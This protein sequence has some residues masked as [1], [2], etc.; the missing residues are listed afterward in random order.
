MAK[1]KKTLTELLAGKTD[2]AEV[3]AIAVRYEKRRQVEAQ[4]EARRRKL[5]MPIQ[6]RNKLTYEAMTAEVWTY[7]IAHYREFRQWYVETQDGA[8][9]STDNG[10]Q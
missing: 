10:N 9:L 4:A 5:F 1:N 7:A 8:T 2:P 6:T 3:A